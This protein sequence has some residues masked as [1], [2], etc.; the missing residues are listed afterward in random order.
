MENNKLFNLKLTDLAKNKI[1]NLLKEEKNKNKKFRIYISGGGCNGFQYNF[2]LDEKINKEDH[3]ILFLDV[4]IVIDSISLQ[5]LI[6]GVVDYKEELL[7]SC[8]F[9]INPN[10]KTTCSCGTSFSI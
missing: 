1:K 5:Y 8:F 2:I 7:E 3:L 4:E 6:G 9:V 10:A